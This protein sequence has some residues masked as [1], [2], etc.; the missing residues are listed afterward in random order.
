[1]SNQTDTLTD[2]ARRARTVASGETDTA[3]DRLVDRS[4]PGGRRGNP[5]SR[6]RQQR[7]AEEI[8][9]EID[10]GRE[11]VGTVDRIGG[12]DIFLRSEGTEQFGT[13]VRESF[14]SEAD[15]VEAGDVDPR[16]DSQAIAAQPFVAPDRRPT[17]AER[18]RSQ[19]AADAQFIEA[20]DLRAEVGGLGVESL[21]VREGRRSTV[22]ERTRTGLAADD[23]FAEPGDFAVEVGA[24]GI[25][26]ARATDTGQRRIAARQ[27]AAETPVE[28]FDPATDIQATD[29]GFGLTSDA[30][31]EVAARQFESE[32]DLFGTGELDPASDVRATD[33]GFGLGEGPAREIA[34]ANLESQLDGVDVDPADIQLE[35]T[36]TGGFEAI[37]E[38]E[39]RR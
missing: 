3:V 29:G 33:S 12:L 21:A 10:I 15:F 19:T 35:P 24:T 5:P 17:V 37:F 28:T 23:P 25:E 14:A 31:R 8:A 26:S 38:R 22:A 1:M 4:D 39:V 36:E 32:F 27:F 13:N 6:V 7:R 18:A 20:G 34:A 11:G 2:R 9:E 30:Q 16:V